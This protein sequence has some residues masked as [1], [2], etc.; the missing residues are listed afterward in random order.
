MATVNY[1]DGI[2]MREAQFIAQ[3]YC[4]D[5]GIKDVFITHPEVQQYSFDSGVWE[6][7][8]QSKSL[9]MADSRYRILINKTT[10]AIE[11][12]AYEED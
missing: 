1:S 6:I 2:D 7:I 4:L 8:F 3:K 10:G 5:K 9:A 11:Y 12:S